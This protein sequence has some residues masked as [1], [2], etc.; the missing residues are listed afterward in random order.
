MNVST[1]LPTPLGLNL[2]LLTPQPG[3]FA[4]ALP[5]S[6]GDSYSQALA[7][8]VC[9]LPG[10][11]PARLLS[12]WMIF[13]GF[14]LRTSHTTTTPSWDATANFDPLAEKEDEKDAGTGVL[15]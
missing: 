1:S 13:R 7:A 8:P 10:V 3:A 9:T 12:V 11:V 6:H 14:V 4:V 5:Q 2:T 15:W